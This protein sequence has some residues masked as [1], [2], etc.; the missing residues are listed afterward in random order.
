MTHD[1]TLDCVNMWPEFSSLNKLQGIFFVSSE[2]RVNQS[3][4][5]SFIPFKPRTY[6]KT[7]RLT[8]IPSVL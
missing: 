3:A 1:L 4:L 7:F 6:A 2:S 8:N 5:H